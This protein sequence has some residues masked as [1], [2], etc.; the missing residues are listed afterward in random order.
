MNG[1]Y[2]TEYFDIID[3]LQ[4]DLPG[5]LGAARFMQQSSAIV[6]GEVVPSTFVPRLYGAETRALFIDATNM[7]SSILGKAMDRFLSDERYRSLF[8]FDDRIVE[9]ALAPRG[10]ASHIPIARFDLFLNEETGEWHFCEFNTDGTSGMNEDREIFRSIEGSPSYQ[11]FSE[12]H[13][14][15]PNE[16]FDS[17]IDTFL[18]VYRSSP[19]AVS[20]PTVAICDYLD[21]STTQ[22]LEAYCSRFNERGV[23]CRMVDVRALRFD[24]ESNM[25][26]DADGT[27]IDA[28]WRRFVCKDVLDRW[29]D[30]QALVSAILQ[31]GT[32]LIGGFLNQI[33]H[34]K[35]I[36]KVLRDPLTQEFLSAEEREFVDQH[37]PFTEYLDSGLVDIDDITAHKDSWV[38]KP[39]DDYGASDV[40]VG[41]MY[42]ENEWRDI[43]GAHADAASGRPFL[44]QRFVSPYATLTMPAE[45]LTGADD[46]TLSEH[47]L[48]QQAPRAPYN[49]LTGMYAF[50][51]KFSG[52]FSRLGPH[53]IVCGPYGGVTAATL[54]VDC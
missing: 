51:G 7:I 5:R 32:V 20:H 48:S 4:G 9:L 41:P 36:F 31:G 47:M 37:I 23:N 33:A 2:T 46:S 49:N 50:D 6:H 39:T 29:D 35:R 34:D 24:E 11:V 53:S 16:L 28:V 10:Y 19:K 3:S 27:P 52:V 38:I 54:W 14:A 45:V 22:E 25:L 30:S 26:L 1:T 13:H 44:A 17:W 40:F 15:A 43:V 18:A 42:S 21:H 8:G 12:H